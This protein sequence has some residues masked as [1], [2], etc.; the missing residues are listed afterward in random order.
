MTDN[1]PIQIDGS[2]GEG[3]GQILRTSLAL[4]MVT[5]RAIRVA[6]IR[7]ARKKPGL[8][9]QHL[10]AVRAAAEVAQAEVDGAEIGSR[11]LTFTPGEVR[12]GEYRF[13]IGTAGSATLVLQTVLPPLMIAGGPSQLVLE[14]G[15][16]NPM[17]PPV[18]FLQK[19]FLPL[20]GRMGPQVDVDLQRHG[21]YPA[22]GGRVRVRIQPSAP[23]TPIDLLER[24]PIRRQRARAIVANLPRHVA[25][26]EVDT[27]RRKLGWK[28][29][30]TRVEVVDSNG[31]GNALM[32]EIESQ[33]VTEVFT[34][35]G[36]RHVTAEKVA[37]RAAKQAKAYL[38]AGVPAAE[39][40][41]DQ[42]LIPM[43][44]AGGG[45][46]RTLAPTEHTRTNIE[47]IQKFLDVEIR[48]EQ[49]ESELCQIEVRSRPTPG[50][51]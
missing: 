11:E 41:A 15:T 33:H 27:A 13:D 19:V 16:H 38:Q 24:G 3:G 29:K 22:G 25:E 32:L 28:P 34:G 49:V 39:H 8:R 46:F 40:L 18:D 9:Q 45:R 47:I 30:W 31:P 17:A 36:E 43:A 5:R 44:M 10:T 50:D 6:K 35:F 1:D 23:L 14:G 21:F 4:A 7:A 2:F 42:L 26:R 12:P 51:K 48:V 20:L 37:A